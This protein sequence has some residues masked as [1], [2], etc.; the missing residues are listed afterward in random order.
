MATVQRP[1][2]RP[3]VLTAD[4]KATLVHFLEYLRESFSYKLAGLT[5]EEARRRLVPSG[6]SL[7]GLAKHLAGVE[8][9]WFCSTFAG[10]EVNADRNLKPDETL[11]SVLDQYKTACARAD[12]VIAACSD[13][14]QPCARIRPDGQQ[15]T[16]RWVLTHIV[17]ETAR[18]A[19]HADILREQIDGQVGR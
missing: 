3:P 5:D 1:D 11:A 18:H 14:S 4:E 15:P 8:L 12:E 16:F 9:G 13:M 2:K 6:T 10:Q 7:I 17:E 19:G